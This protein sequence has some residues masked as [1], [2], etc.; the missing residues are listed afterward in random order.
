MVERVAHCK[1]KLSHILY[2]M[3]EVKQIRE[4][5]P[6]LTLED[7]EGIRDRIDQSKRLL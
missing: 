1:D 3:S 7:Y 6:E 2:L 5:N 4:S